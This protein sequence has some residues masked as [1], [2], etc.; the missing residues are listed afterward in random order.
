MKCAK[1]RFENRE[2]ML[3][4]MGMDWWPARVHA[5]YAELWKREGN[6]AKAKESLR[7]AIEIFQQC[8]ADAWVAR[9][10]EEIARL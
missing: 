6:R 3:K 1:C 4:E 9:Y 7:K 8:G 2:G 10:E 5:A